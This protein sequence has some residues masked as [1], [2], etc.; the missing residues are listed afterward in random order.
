MT[1][2]SP[3]NKIKTSQLPQNNFLKWFHASFADAKLYSKDELK[4][5]LETMADFYNTEIQ[6]HEK[7]YRE[8]YDSATKSL[9]DAYNE[10]AEDYGVVLV[11]KEMWETLMAAIKE[12]PMLAKEWEEFSMKIKLCQE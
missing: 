5:E 7:E 8:G 10:L 11:E 1:K 6:R 12:N 9:K 4:L 3:K 2:N